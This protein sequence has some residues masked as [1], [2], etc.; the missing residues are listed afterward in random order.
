MNVVKTDN[1]QDMIP[2]HDAYDH[3]IDPEQEPTDNKKDPDAGI[4]KQTIKTE[5]QRI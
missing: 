3:Y 2:K 4:Y 5:A 1:G